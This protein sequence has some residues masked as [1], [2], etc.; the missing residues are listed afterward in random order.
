MD[1]RFLDISIVNLNNPLLLTK[2]TGNDYLSNPFSFELT[3]LSENRNLPVNQLIGKSTS[4]RM[5]FLNLT[6]QYYNGL[7]SSVRKGELNINGLQAYIFLIHPWLWFLHHTN[8]RRVFCANQ[9]MTV[10]EIVSTVFKNNNMVDFDLSRLKKNYEPLKYCVQ[11][12]E[13]DFNFISRLLNQAG[14]YYYFKHSKDKH[15]LMLED[16]GYLS[17]YY[18]EDVTSS[19]QT[20]SEHHLYDLSFTSDSIQREHVI[21]DYDF[22]HPSNLREGNS[23]SLKSNQKKP[24]AYRYELTTMDASSNPLTAAATQQKQA[25]KLFSSNRIEAKSSYLNFY[26]GTVINLT[27]QTITKENGKQLIY[28]IT[29]H[30]TDIS[31]R[32][33]HMNEQESAHQYE[34]HLK[35][36]P[37]SLHFVPSARYLNKLEITQPNIGGFETAMVV[38]PKDNK[39]Y[40]DKSGRIKIQFHWDRHGKLNENSSYWVRVRQFWASD[41][42][43]AQF[44]PRVGQEVLVAFEEGNPDR[45]IVMGVLANENHKPPFNPEK[46]PTQSGFKTHSL[47]SKNP[48]YGNMLRFEDKANNE[49][50]DMK[51][52]KKMEVKVG[53]KCKKVIE[54]KSTTTIQKG[55]Y[56]SV[57]EGALSI[58][59]KENITIACGDSEILITGEQIIVKSQAIHFSQK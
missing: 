39:I 32:E 37:A 2:V 38:G 28:A 31:H 50:I 23:S 18:P 30:A 10:A 54:G 15:T 57:V 36:Y 21:Q 22:R 6:P 29:H 35:A 53:T 25:D 24:E 58:Q 5:G 7:I 14:I 51:A 12:D 27:G 26:A 4:I 42:Y 20:H 44:M 59:A 41:R 33:A 55:D 56:I 49:S 48:E 47:G 52:Q 43:G 46:F 16:S 1:S 19:D 11:H 34:N 40:T 8:D 45:P 9:P 13:S 3:V 17:N